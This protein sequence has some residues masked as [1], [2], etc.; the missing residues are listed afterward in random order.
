MFSRLNQRGNR[1]VSTAQFQDTPWLPME[2][3][4]GPEGA[5]RR[6]GIGTKGSLGESMK[7]R[8]RLSS[9]REMMQQQFRFEGSSVTVSAFDHSSSL[10]IPHPFSVKRICAPRLPGG[11]SLETKSSSLILRISADA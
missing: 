9:S 10:S 3:V 2:A 6:F 5:G 4:L 8:R 1:S 11:K 7:Q